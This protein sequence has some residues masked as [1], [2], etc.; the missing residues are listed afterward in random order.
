MSR[1]DSILLIAFGGPE[2]PEDIRPFLKNV[3]EGRAIPPERLEEVAQHYE[4]I[5]G[6]SP[7]NDLTRLQAEGLRR[8]LRRENRF[9]RVYIGMR[10]W[11]PFL[12]ES[13]AEMKRNG[14]LR[15]LGIILS[16]FQTEASWDRYLAD[17]A[18]A[19]ARVGAGCPDVE[20][21]G[22]WADHPLFLDAMVDRARAA[23]EEV[24]AGRRA[25]APL[26]FT[27]HSVPVGMA[28]DS[29]YAAQL[30]TAATTIA[31]RLGHARW[32]L[33]YQSRSGSPREPW[34]EPDIGD[35]LRALGREGVTDAVVAPIGFVC[36]HVEVLYDLDI[37]AC[38]VA[39][40]CGL[41]LH[42]ATAANDH[43]AFIEM[44]ADLVRRGPAS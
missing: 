30:Q 15:A 26:I 38:R 34:L 22:H 27:A 28:S 2:K 42:R 8:V 23:L 7:I 6:R 5:G 18:R 43:P 33:A 36:D 21:A 39:R 19:R 44:L 24:P 9:E 35:V 10:N 29:P 13:L 12:H 16:S 3:A 31:E 41:T 32:T 37:G 40:E 1:C 20:F 25:G 14:H 11:H 4:A 17:V